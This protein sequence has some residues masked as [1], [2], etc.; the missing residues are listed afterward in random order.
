M[1]LVFKSSMQNQDLVTPDYYEQELKYQKVIDD[2]NRANSLSSDLKYEIKKEEIFITFP[3]EV[4]DI[5]IDAN[6]LLY[7]TA[8]QKKDLQLQLAT[9]NGKIHFPIKDKNKGLHEIR[10][11]WIANGK[12]YFFQDKLIIE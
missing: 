8:D 7:C 10:I 3:A 4:S 2:R 11:S 5:P 9:S 12:S 6:I 1:V